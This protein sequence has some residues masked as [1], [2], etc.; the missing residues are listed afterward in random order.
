MYAVFFN[1]CSILYL[2]GLA[3]H[4]CHCCGSGIADMFN[5]PNFY[6]GTGYPKS[7]HH[8]YVVGILPTELSLSILLNLCGLK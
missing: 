4:P 6:I 2:S 8:G 3:D 1:L 7:G 5:W